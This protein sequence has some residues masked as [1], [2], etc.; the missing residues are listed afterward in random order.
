MTESRRPCTP[1]DPSRGAPAGRA[2]PAAAPGATVIPKEDG[3][4]PRQTGGG[5]GNGHRDG[6][7]GE[8]PGPADTFTADT[9]TDGSG[10]AGDGQIALDADSAAKGRYAVTASA[11]SWCSRHW[12]ACSPRCGRPAAPRG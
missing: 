7:S 4:P 1:G 3:L 11:S 9:F 2:R 12:W 8:G 10:P 6:R 5:P